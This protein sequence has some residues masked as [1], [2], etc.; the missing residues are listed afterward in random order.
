MTRTGRGLV[1]YALSWAWENGLAGSVSAALISGVEVNAI[2]TLVRNWRPRLGPAAT[3]CGAEMV[4]LPDL[5][6]WWPTSSKT[7][8]AR[9]KLPTGF[10]VR[11]VTQAGPVRPATVTIRVIS[12]G[13]SASSETFTLASPE[14][15]TT[16]PTTKDV[17]A[18]PEAQISPCQF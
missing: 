1:R 15:R 9:V 16:A 4:P 13:S 6:R 8:I 5:H 17:R 14:A 3:V 2:A 18:V 11:P 7:L 10:S 12:T